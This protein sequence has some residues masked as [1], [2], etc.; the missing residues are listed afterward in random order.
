MILQFLEMQWH[1]NF[2]PNSLKTHSRNLNN[3]I[4]ETH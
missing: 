2:F 1:K 4:K 3:K